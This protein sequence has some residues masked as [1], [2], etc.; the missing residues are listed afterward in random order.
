MKDGRV[1]ADPGAEMV[2]IDD[3]EDGELMAMGVAPLSSLSHTAICSAKLMASGFQNGC[4][5]AHFKTTRAA[6]QDR[7]A[8]N[9][10]ISSMVPDK[11]CVARASVVSLWNQ[12]DCKH[13]AADHRNLVLTVSKLE[14][15]FLA[16]SLTLPK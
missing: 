15:T 10:F 5:D 11:L 12:S 7:R 1:A 8:L 4:V 13:W 9:R 2:G 16:E 14:M 6:F 3:M